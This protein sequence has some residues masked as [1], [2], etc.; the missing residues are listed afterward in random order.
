VY[1]L[2]A[3]GSSDPEDGCSWRGNYERDHFHSHLLFWLSEPESPTS[4]LTATF[5][6]VF[7]RKTFVVADGYAVSAPVH[8]C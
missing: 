3:F 1:R 4:I 5:S 7:P 8:T 2:S 6:F